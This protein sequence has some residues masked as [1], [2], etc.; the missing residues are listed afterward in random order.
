MSLVPA[1][2]VAAFTAFAAALAYGM[3]QTGPGLRRGRR[4]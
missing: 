4:R 2:I 1:L 3:W